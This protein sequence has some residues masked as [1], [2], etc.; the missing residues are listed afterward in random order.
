MSGCVQ[1]GPFALKLETADL[2]TN[3][4]SIRLPEQQFQIL[5]LLVQKNGG[6]VSREHIRKALWPNDT[7]VEFDRS[8][9]AAILKLRLALRESSGSDSWIETIPRRGYR[10]LA[11]ATTVAEASDLKESLPSPRQVRNGNLVG[12][13]I[14]H[15]RVLGVLGG[16]GMGVVYKGED[17]KLGRP[18]ALKFLAEE[19]S[20]RPSILKRLECEARTASSMSH[21]N[22]CTVYEIGEHEGQP[23]IVMEYLEGEN[24]RDFIDRTW[25]SPAAN[26]HPAE[27][28]RLLQF[29]IQIAHALSAAHERG[30]IHRDLKPANV[31]VTSAGI[32]KLLDFGVAQK[33]SVDPG[34]S[35]DEAG[36]GSISGSIDYM[37]PE[38]AAGEP[39]DQRSDLFSFGVMISELLTGAHPFRREGNFEAG[40]VDLEKPN[41]RG[42]LPQN[43]LVL[44][45]RLLSRSLELR[46]QSISEVIADLERVQQILAHGDKPETPHET[47]LIGRDQEFAR[48]KRAFSQAMTGHGSM[49]MIGGEPGIGKSHLSRAM[50]EEARRRGAL[51]VIGH[52]YEMEGA[53]PYA[54]FIEILEYI[55]RM[56]P[57]EG[58][59]YS[60]GDHASEVARLV[61]ELRE[62][63]PE[64][65]PPIQLPPEQQRRY[66]FNAFRSF[67]ERST[68]VTPL[69]VVFEDLQWADET[70]LLLI[71]HHAQTI[72]NTALLVL[73]TYRDMDLEVTRPFARTLEALLRRKLA[74]RLPL[75][76]LPHGGVKEMLAALS[77]QTPPP[78]LVKAIFEETDGNPFFVEEVF[79]HL[80]EEGR[81]F[82]ESG[83]W[84]SD[85]SIGKLQ[86][87]ESIRLVLGRRLE[88]LGDDAR[89]VLT[90]A[91]VIGRSFSLRLLEHLEGK[92]P[93]IA[94]EA[95]EEAEHAH[96]LV[97]EPEGRDARYR[98]VHELVRQTLAESLSLP[99]R[100]RLH[101]R[102]ADAIETVNAGR[103]ES[104]TTQLAHHLYQAGAAADPE[105][106]SAYLVLAA[107]QARARSAHE[108]ALGHLD[109]ALSIRED[110]ADRKTAELLEQKASTLRSL[111][112]PDD[113]VAEYRKA[114]DLFDTAGDYEKMAQASIA[115][116]YL[117]AWRHDPEGANRTMK[118]AHESALAHDPQVLSS[119]LSMRAA[120]MSAAAEPATAEKMFEEARSL[121]N[122]DSVPA[123]QPHDMLEA[124]HFYQSFQ[125]QR[126]RTACRHVAAQCL[127]HGDAWGASSVEFYGI[128]AELYCGRP[129]DGAAMISAAMDRAE[130]I[131]HHG[132]IWALKNAASIASAAR[133][134][135]AA[136]LKETIE[137]WDFGDA[138][139]LGWNFAT[140]LQRGH[141]AL[142]SGDLNLAEELYSHG[143]NL[144]ERSYMSD[145][146]EAC[147]FAAWA[148]F[149]DPRAANAWKNR[150]W[151]LPVP[152]QLNSLGIWNAFERTVIGLAH[153]ERK[154]DL[155]ALSE[156]A[157]DLLQTGA[158]M[159][160]I[161]CPFRT[162]AGI[163][164]AAA[165]DWK[166][167][168]HH[169][170]EAVRQTDVA[171][172]RHLQPAAR[173]WY[174]RMLL[175]RNGKGDRKQAQKLLQAAISMYESTG[176]PH[177]SIH[178]RQLLERSTV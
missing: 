101:L 106:T 75:R 53:P 4:C 112:R 107:R 22:I 159:Y 31:F 94:I 85:V 169:H 41:L 115:L 70:T 128:W 73:C 42:D 173:E 67:V 147:L 54:P 37:S 163:V 121:H 114:I 88:R 49:V 156:I 150:T 111:G 17:L 149:G 9:N 65:P 56:A 52:C 116:A 165:G 24:L 96:L 20:R 2:E 1:F 171:P 59:R 25:K 117:Q 167:S 153:L 118:R 62:M 102:I 63:Y 178:A 108:E 84:L 145:F 28:Q 7:I 39:T 90:T 72:S 46:Y 133:G 26:S 19:Y 170:L 161:L 89:R 92:D 10:L 82:D 97:P 14:S 127:A 76:R 104:Q 100:Q 18:V 33:S 152:G 15:Y 3:G 68:S 132:A 71:Q 11:P 23:F 16:G 143:I 50:V 44:I 134:D 148:E 8:I 119:I 57:R 164:A 124:I 113:A 6:V 58:L 126:V 79:R 144:N 32:V 120:I 123:L 158:W 110:E 12:Q 35:S 91:A 168:E 51:A 155:A 176:M 5:L 129:E 60:L 98:F 77:G 162:I 78:S 105:K 80:A 45:R 29:A 131:G 136:S 146:A 122:A 125:L 174:A 86:V 13:R 137:A 95:V 64:I 48:L 157:D 87:P 83:K 40:I 142:W 38:Q 27:L 43:V 61:P 130:K 30:I 177:R 69:L 47:P 55:T 139:D 21:P 99:R 151:K 138:H 166:L 154:Q 34:D 109:L 103:L 74:S 140:S 93:D 135:L 141:F 81:L 160:T 172:Y 66:L 36:T 175:E